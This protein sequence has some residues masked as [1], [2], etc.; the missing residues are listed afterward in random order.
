[1]QIHNEQSPLAGKTV[2]IISGRYKD[3]QFKVEDWWDRLNQG[4]WMFARGNPACLQYAIRNSPVGDDLPID[5]EVL[6]G[7]IDGLGYLIHIS[8][9]ENQYHAKRYIS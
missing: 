3:L 2:K 1:M 6:Y 8:E 9:I 5:D 4:S 7:K